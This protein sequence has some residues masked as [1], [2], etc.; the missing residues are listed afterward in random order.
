MEIRLLHGSIFFVSF[1]L[2]EL[3]FATTGRGVLAWRRYI[4][5]LRFQSLSQAHFLFCRDTLSPVFLVVDAAPNNLSFDVL[6]SRFLFFSL[7]VG[8]QTVVFAT[9]RRC[10]LLPRFDV[11]HLALVRM[12]LPGSL[13]ADRSGLLA[14]HAGLVL[15]A[16]AGRRQ[17]FLVGA[18]FEMVTRRVHVNGCLILTNIYPVHWNQYVL[19][20]PS[21][22]ASSKGK[23][24]PF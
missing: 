13:G 20:K 12:L 15:L 7:R 3:V 8:S 16:A 14:T 21:P 11:A 18:T 17:Q 22:E 6:E 24:G 2:L 9:A 5:S 4:D 1:S 23:H 19:E 10:H